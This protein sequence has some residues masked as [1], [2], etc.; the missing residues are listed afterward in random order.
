MLK[1]GGRGWR[2]KAMHHIDPWQL[3]DGSW[4]AVV[5]GARCLKEPKTGG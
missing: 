3:P 2:S 1:A 4:R 5:D